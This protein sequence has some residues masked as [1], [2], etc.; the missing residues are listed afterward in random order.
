MIAKFLSVR[1]GP[2]VE[3]TL[4]TAL[5]VAYLITLGLMLN[6][7][8]PRSGSLAGGVVTLFYLIMFVATLAF[9]RRRGSLAAV[10]VTR[11]RWLVGSILG[12]LIGGMGLLGTMGSFPGGVFR[13]P[14]WP[15][16]LALLAGG[17]SAGFVEALALYGYFQLRWEEAFG[18]VVAVL[19]SAGVWT[20]AHGAVLALPGGGTYVAQRV[21]VGSFLL[22]LLVTFSIIGLI[23]HF[24]R[25]IWVSVVQNAVMGNVLTNLYMYSIAPD[26]VFLA[27]PD[28]LPTALAVALVVVAGLVWVSRSQVA[29]SEPIS[30][31]G[32]T[33]RV[34]PPAGSAGAGVAEAP[35][36]VRTVTGAITL[37]DRWGHFLAR[38]G[39]NRHNRRVEP[40]LY[41]LGDPRPESPVF[42]SANYTLSFDA[43]R[44]ALAG[45]DGYILVLDT[46]GVNVWCAAGKGTFGTD[47]LVHQIE[48]TSLASR[49]R[50]RRLILPQLGAPGVAAHEVKRRTGF[51]VE[52]GP[53]RAADLPTYLKAR[54][55]RPEMRRVRFDLPDRLVL[56]PVE[57]V[58]VVV[59][60]LLASAALFF[61]GGPLASAGA[62]AA[63]LA[64][65]VLFP[66]L[67]PWL[68]TP[69]FSTKGF[70]L[71]ALVALPFAL[72]ALQNSPTRAWWLRAASALVYLLAMPAATAFLALNFTGSTT[73]TSRSGVRR[74]IF[75]Y[76]PIMAWTFGAAL[77]LMLAL[78]AVR[79]LGG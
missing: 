29:H 60:T 40:G 45:V 38:W 44:S 68:P 41:A 51:G 64:G 63:T 36:P 62:A 67:L 17:L 9:A 69:N 66:L 56:I 43:L 8:A 34:H 46:R 2:T 19:G 59:P 11:R 1:F 4:A 25:N 39:V 14:N 52:Y 5:V 57:L 65:V 32:C 10:G 6:W 15:S 78:V 76:V 35:A 50:H 28:S 21:G 71:G 49:V 37:A 7:V 30:G 26:Q 79:A 74:E 75:T 16:L 31:C 12:V 54:Q 72:L 22:T 20:I 42:V 3:T 24:T 48:A 27:R 47:E 23:V 53:V 13:L 73:F 61:L 55:A 70:I 58:H 33:A 77:V 18:P